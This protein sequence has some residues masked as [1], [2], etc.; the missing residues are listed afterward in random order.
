MVSLAEKMA[1]NMDSSVFSK[2][3]VNSKA[4]VFLS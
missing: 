4:T 1:A 2:A 3:T